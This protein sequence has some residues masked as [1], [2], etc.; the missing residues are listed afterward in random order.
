MIPFDDT[1]AMSQ[2]KLYYL[3]VLNKNVDIYR[4]ESKKAKNCKEITQ[5]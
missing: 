5:T 3:P 2:M 1:F 4:K